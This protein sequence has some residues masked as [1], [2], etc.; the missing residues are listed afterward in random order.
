M[1]IQIG[2]LVGPWAHPHMEPCVCGITFTSIPGAWAPGTASLIAY[3]VG[4]ACVD[5]Y[6]ERVAL[7]PFLADAAAAPARRTVG[8]GRSRTS[9]A[10]STK[11]KGPVGAVSGLC[12]VCLD[13]QATHAFVPC[14]H[15][16]VCL[17]C[18]QH[19]ITRRSACPICRSLPTSSLLIHNV[20]A[21]E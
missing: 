20:T 6:V 15:L 8:A 3:F 19:I 1:V 14:G 2:F 21:P 17:S 13:A 10:P 11:A 16:S 18:C 5:C 9:T 12:V 4:L 7:T